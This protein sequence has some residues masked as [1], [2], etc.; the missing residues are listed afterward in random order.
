M[1]A[2]GACQN[3]STLLEGRYCRYCGQ[4]AAGA[5]DLRIGPM[6]RDLL[7][8]ASVLDSK[9]LRSLAGLFRPGFLTA[10][11]IAGRRQP[12]LNP[13]KLYL[14]CAAVFFVAAPLAGYT[15]EALRST[16]GMHWLDSAATARIEARRMDPALFAAR[17]DIRMQSVYTAMLGLSIVANALMLG[18]LFRRPR[19]P[20]GLHLLFGIHYVAFLYLAAIALGL[21]LPRLAAHP[22]I[23]VLLTYAV[24]ASY[25]YTA[26][27]RVYGEGRFRTLLKTAALALFGSVFDSIVNL[28]AMLLT[29]R[30]V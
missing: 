25:L 14:V 22:E 17:F 11:Y 13:V 9:V 23:I 2:S 28:L 1:S 5:D 18:L 24:V 7:R 10:E 8:R 4:R 29:L 26:L 12:Y 19:R 20:F 27:R 15:L 6:A 16:P 3:C 30:L 21:A